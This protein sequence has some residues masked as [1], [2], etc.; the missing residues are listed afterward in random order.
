MIKCIFLVLILKNII[1]NKKFHFTAKLCEIRK[2]YHN[3]YLFFF[4]EVYNASYTHFFIWC[5]RWTT[6]LPSFF[7]KIWGFILKKRSAIYDS[8]FCPSLETTSFH[9]CENFRIPSRKNDAYF[10]T[11]YELMNI[12]TRNSVLK[13]CLFFLASG[14]GVNL[15]SAY[16]ADRSP[17]TFTFYFILDLIFSDQVLRI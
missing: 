5:I 2:K 3:L 7:P 6:L 17:Q 4:K 10:E 12:I 14:K 13:L 9:L 15:W 11:I 8:K 1:E 16:I